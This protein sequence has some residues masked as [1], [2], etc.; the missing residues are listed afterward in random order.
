MLPSCRWSYWWWG[1]GKKRNS[2]FPRNPDFLDFLINSRFYY[3]NGPRD[4][5]IQVDMMLNCFLIPQRRPA[6]YY[7]RQPSTVWSSRL[8]PHHAGQ[9][10][11]RQ[12]FCKTNVQDRTF[13]TSGHM[14]NK[15][16]NIVQPRMAPGRVNERVTSPNC[17]YQTPRNVCTAAQTIQVS[18]RAE[19]NVGTRRPVQWHKRKPQT[20]KLCNVDGRPME[21]RQSRNKVEATQ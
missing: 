14:W 1:P 4:K 15:A 13:A 5:F 12:M 6:L 3:I 11:N 7:I 18:T 8:H 9:F 10:Q 2:N 16:I 17:A 20:G 21:H 19:H